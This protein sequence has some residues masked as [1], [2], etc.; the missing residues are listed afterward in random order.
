[1]SA[2]RD[3]ARFLL[4]AGSDGCI[5]LWCLDCRVGDDYRLLASTTNSSLGRFNYIS[6][7]H[8]NA[9]HEVAS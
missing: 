1:M 3:D 6:V 5:G 2:P 8:E 4:Q 9:F 7:E